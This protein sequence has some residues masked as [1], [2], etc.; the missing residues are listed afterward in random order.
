MVRPI[1]HGDSA[2]DD[3]KPRQAPMMHGF[4][5]PFLHSRNKV[6]WNRSA[7]NLVLEVEAL[8]AR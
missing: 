1:V 2:I 6:A 3:R 8:S 4:D 7:N 5:D